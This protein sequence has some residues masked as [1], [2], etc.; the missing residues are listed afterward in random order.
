MVSLFKSSFTLGIY[1][2][3]IFPEQI[4]YLFIS[5]KH[6]TVN[7]LDFKN[8]AIAHICICGKLYNVNAEVIHYYELNS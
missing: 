8:Q 7:N 3:Y 4:A 6:E 1:R 2:L 5:S